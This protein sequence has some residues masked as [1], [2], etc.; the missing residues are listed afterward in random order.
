MITTTEARKLIDTSNIKVDH[1]LDKIEIG[2]VEAATSGKNTYVVY[3]TDLWSSFEVGKD[4][5]A[6][7]IQNRVGEELAK[8]GYHVRLGTDGDNYVPHGLADDDGEGPSYINWC[9]KIS[10]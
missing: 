4:I 1:F 3:F 8:L 7:P 6:T 5:V 9:L 10:W 2:I